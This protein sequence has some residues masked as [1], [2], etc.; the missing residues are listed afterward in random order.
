MEAIR[1]ERSPLQFLILNAMVEDGM[2]N[3]IAEGPKMVKWG[4]A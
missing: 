2:T 1:L 3:T 4:S